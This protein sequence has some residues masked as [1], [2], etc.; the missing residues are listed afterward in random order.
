MLAPDVQDLA[1]LVATGEQL[2]AAVRLQPFTAGGNELAITVSV[3]VALAHAGD[4]A[5]ALIGAADLALYAAKDAGRDCV[6][7]TPQRAA[8]SPR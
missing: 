1:S 2:R 3:G 6:R 4:G 5:D 7:S 8:V